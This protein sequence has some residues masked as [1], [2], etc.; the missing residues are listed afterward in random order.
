MKVS[1]V[2]SKKSNRNNQT[3]LQQ[4]F[5]SVIFLNYQAIHRQ[6]IDLL[7]QHEHSIQKFSKISDVLRIGSLLTGSLL[8]F[9]A[10]T[11]IQFRIFMA[12]TVLQFTI[13][14]S[15]LLNSKIKK[16]SQYR[17]FISRIFTLTVWRGPMMLVP[18][19]RYFFKT[20]IFPSLFS[21]QVKSSL[22]RMVGVNR[23]EITE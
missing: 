13:K 19:D 23:P 1:L 6:S 17:F 9:S 3:D 10:S 8:T 22:N 21:L 4:G 11:H 5:L 15:C 14:L 20:L 12:R 18:Y 7:C 2:K 16:F